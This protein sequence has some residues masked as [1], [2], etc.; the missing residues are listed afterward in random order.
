MVA[1]SDFGGLIQ[2][3]VDAGANVVLLGAGLPTTLPDSLPLD[4]LNQVATKFIPIVS[5]ARAAQLVFK[6]WKK[7]YNHVPDAVVVEGPMAGGHLGFRREQ[8]FDPEF[9]LEKI[10]PPVIETVKAYEDEFGR[11]IPVIAAGGIY[12]GQDIYDIMQLGAKGVQMGTRFVTTHECDASPAFKQA[13]LDCKEEDIIIINSPVGLPGRAIRGKFFE[14]VISGVKEKFKCDW[15]CLRSC[16]FKK[17]PYCIAQALTNAK[18]GLLDEGFAFAGANA[19][20]VEKIISVQE[21]ID[22][23]V[24][25]YMAAAQAAI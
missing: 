2:C 1:L 3:S 8:I 15:K 18:K 25:E 22:K 17:V 11:Q 16:D 24:A 20:R 14:R 23:L 9:A 13:Y 21:L 19:Y 4:D 10:L 5:S 6:T 12:T 7:R